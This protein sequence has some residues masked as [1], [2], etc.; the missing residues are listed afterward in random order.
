MKTTSPDIGSVAN[1]GVQTAMEFLT[2]AMEFLTADKLIVSHED[3]EN[4][5]NQVN[6]NLTGRVCSPKQV[7]KGESIPEGEGMRS[8][9]IQ[10][11]D[12]KVEEEII[13]EQDFIKVAEPGNDESGDVIPNKK[14]ARLSRLGQCPARP[15]TN[16][17]SPSTALTK[18]PNALP[19]GLADEPPKETL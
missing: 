14:R 3:A 16:V 12:E 17:R 10:T 19:P 8:P 15:M 6:L 9:G 2:A 18:Q 1:I 13:L 4:D 7:D 11:K 5:M